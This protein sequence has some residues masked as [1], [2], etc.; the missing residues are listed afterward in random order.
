MS[1]VNHARRQKKKEMDSL[2][3]T[4]KQFRR[5]TIKERRAKLDVLNTLK[6]K[7]CGKMTYF[8]HETTGFCK[9]CT[10]VPRGQ[11]QESRQ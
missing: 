9:G 4:G 3:L 5:E 2:G 10:V 7:K 11:T 6:C 1:A 8:V